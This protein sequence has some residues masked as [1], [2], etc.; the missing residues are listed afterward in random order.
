MRNLLHFLQVL[1][2]QQ[3]GNVEEEGSCLMRQINLRDVVRC[4]LLLDLKLGQ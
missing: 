4:E 2:V 1:R 3:P